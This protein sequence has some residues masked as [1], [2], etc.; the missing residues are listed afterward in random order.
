MNAPA[1]NT[2][3]TLSI[4]EYRLSHPQTAEVAT[5]TQS[6]VIGCLLERRRLRIE[7]ALRRKELMRQALALPGK[8]AIHAWKWTK[9]V[10]ALHA[11]RKPE[12]VTSAQR[13]SFPK[14]N[15]PARMGA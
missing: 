13:P 2:Y 14:F 5:L 7:R 8:T 11:A 15:Q 4:R 12:M 10:M 1:D 9:S 3:R 6:T